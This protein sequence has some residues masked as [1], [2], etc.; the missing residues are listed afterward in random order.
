VSVEALNLEGRAVGLRK[1]ND[2]AV[3]HGAVHVH[4][5]DLNL[6]GAF[7]EA[8]GDFGYAFCHGLLLQKSWRKSLT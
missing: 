7:F 8:C 4:K 6:F 3:R 2:G 1:Q 5:Q